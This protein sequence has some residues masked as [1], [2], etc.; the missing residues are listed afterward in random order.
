MDNNGAGG[1]MSKIGV[2]IVDDIA[3]TRENYSTLLMF[4]RDM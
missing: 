4:G 1:G 3:D 2:L